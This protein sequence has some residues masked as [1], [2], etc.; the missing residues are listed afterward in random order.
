MSRYTKNTDAMREMISNGLPSF[1]SS[2]IRIIGVFI[3]MI[4]LNPILTAIC[5]VML[6]LMSLVTKLIA[7]NSSRFF[8][9]RQESVGKVNGYIEEM[10][11][12]Q[13]VVKFLHEQAVNARFDELTRA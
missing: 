8:K 12:G 7:K 9:A 4:V 5:I 3:M 1:I 13:K 2:G 11:E 6:V 10:I